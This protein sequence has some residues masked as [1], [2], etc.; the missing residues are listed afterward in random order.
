MVLTNT[1]STIWW[2]AG[3]DNVGGRSQ[4]WVLGPENN[5][6]VHL[7]RAIKWLWSTWSGFPQPPAG[8]FK[9]KVEISPVAATNKQHFFLPLGGW[10]SMCSLKCG[11][12]PGWDD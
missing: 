6:E 4:G 7:V 11:E 5:P 10:S 8:S 1:E 12:S 2:A 3:P 9:E